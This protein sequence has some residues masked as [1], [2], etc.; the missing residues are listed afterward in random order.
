M[1]PRGTGIADEPEM[2]FLRS[3]LLS[4]FALAAA[5]TTLAPGEARACGGCMHAEPAPDQPKQSAS[6]VTDHRMVLAL[7]S[8]RVTTLWDQIQYAG[9]PGDFAWVL[10]I[11]GAVVVSVGSNSFIDSLDQQTAPQVHQPSLYCNDGGGDGSSSAG[12][13]CGGFGSSSSDSLASAGGGTA[14]D[15]GADDTGVVI[16]GQSVVGPYAV[17]QIHGRDGDS[18]VSWLNTHKYVI[19]KAILPVLSTYVSEGFD[20]VAVRL[21]PGRGVQ[22]MRPIRVSWQGSTPSLPLRMVAAGVGAKVGIKLFVIGDGRW[23]T[24]SMPSFTLDASKLTWDF[25]TEHSDYVAQRQAKYDSFSGRAFALESSVDI[26]PAS[27][28]FGDDVPPEP[29]A[30]PDGAVD[31]GSDTGIDGAV[32][33]GVDGASDDGIDAD[34][35]S[36][37]AADAAS[38]VAAETSAPYDAGPPPPIDPAS[39]DRAIAFESSYLHRRVTRLRADLPAS[40]L[41]ADLALE[42]DPTQDAI[43]PEIVVG[44]YTHAD[45]V[46]PQ[47]VAY[48]TNG[49]TPA[50]LLAT[51]ASAGAGCSTSS[52]PGSLLAPIGLSMAA[53]AVSLGRRLRRKSA[54]KVD[55]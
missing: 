40:A 12:C 38:D 52:G 49:A 53:I 20:F 42:A 5:S 39:S 13:A 32:D 25:L 3:T 37:A 54:T 55:R 28:P 47:G 10:P 21:R 7:S 45:L 27:I 4:S 2:R 41:D 48:S 34:A 15:A 51:H 14:R 11:R 9:D 44:K 16:T 8:T 6:V 43:A 23:R 24:T 46:C 17:V 1:H 35:A 29:D 50:S 22:S 19:P 30:G 18:I 33:S 36:D 31:T 26:D